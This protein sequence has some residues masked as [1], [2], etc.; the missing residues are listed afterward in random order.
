MEHIKPIL[1]Y[2]LTID[3]GRVTYRKEFEDFLLGHE[4]QTNFSELLYGNIFLR[5]T[6]FYIYE[7]LKA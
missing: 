2:F 6:K 1:K 5:M 7:V 3:L 4:L